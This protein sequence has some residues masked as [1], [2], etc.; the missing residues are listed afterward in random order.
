MPSASIVTM[1]RRRVSQGT[2]QCD[3][4]TH[5]PNCGG[6]NIWVR[7]DDHQYVNPGDCT[8]CADCDAQFDYPNIRFFDGIPELK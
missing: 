3:E 8:Y 7:V 5:C 4:A 6:H 1:K 2:W